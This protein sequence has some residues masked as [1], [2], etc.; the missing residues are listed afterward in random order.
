METDYVVSFKRDLKI[1]WRAVSVVFMILST[2]YTAGRFYGVHRDVT[3]MLIIYALCR[4]LVFDVF[5]NLIQI[6]RTL[7]YTDPLGAS[8][9]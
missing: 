4:E 5:L 3:K 9:F 1:S 2:F 8:C 7:L 6:R